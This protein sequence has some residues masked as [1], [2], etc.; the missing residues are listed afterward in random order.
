MIPRPVT[1]AGTPPAA[2]ASN[3]WTMPGL[4]T[5]LFVPHPRAEVFA[6][7]AAAENLQRLTPPWV[8]FRIVT[9]LPVDM[10]QGARIDYRL[11]VHGVPIGWRTE[12][13]EWE[14]PERFVDTQLAGPYR[15]WIHTHRFHDAPG[16]TLVEDD[17]DFSVPGGWLVERLFVRRDLRQIFLHRQRA[18]LDAFGATASGPLD[19]RFG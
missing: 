13:A 16:G 1:S 10:R 14:P 2:G 7:F 15:R 17:V 4:H 5:S 11:K 19:V 8:D 18:I 6:F 12:I 3:Q 9:P